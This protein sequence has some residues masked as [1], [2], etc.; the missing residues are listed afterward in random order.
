MMSTIIWGTKSGP[1]GARAQCC[2]CLVRLDDGDNLMGESTLSSG[3][4]VDSY[5]TIYE[6]TINNL[7]G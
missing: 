4:A 3:I 6:T 1:A 7:F 2:N 5:G